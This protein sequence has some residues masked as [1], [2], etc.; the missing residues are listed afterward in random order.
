MKPKCSFHQTGWILFLCALAGQAWGSMVVIK[1]DATNIHTMPFVVRTDRSGNALYNGTMNFS[2]IANPKGPPY[3]PADN[4]HFSLNGA[5]L[6]VY[7]GTNLNS[8]LVSSCT[9]AGGKVPRFMRDVKSPLVKNGV[10]YSFEVSLNRLDSVTFEIWYISDLHPAIQAYRFALRSFAPPTDVGI[11]LGR[12]NNRVV[13]AGIRPDSPAAEARLSP[14]LVVQR[15]NG[16]STTGMSRGRA[17]SLLQNSGL[18]LELIDS[19]GRTNVV[20]LM[21]QTTF[22]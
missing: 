19:H 1:V 15:I 22:P 18:W 14:G 4:M 8:D 3:G 7:G 21:T 2:V 9:I 17:E 12:T 20:E 11:S 10:F 16:A 6:S 13:I 5:Y